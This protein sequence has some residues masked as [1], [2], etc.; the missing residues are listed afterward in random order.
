M[1][2]FYKTDIHKD[3]STTD[4]KDVFYNSTV[5]IIFIPNNKCYK[6]WKKQY[7]VFWSF[8]WVFVC[9]FVLKYFE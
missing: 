6:E 1:V 8:V 4:I 3:T 7:N 9:L 5:G 2:I